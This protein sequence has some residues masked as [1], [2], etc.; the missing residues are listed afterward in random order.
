AVRVGGVP[1]GC[2]PPPPDQAGPAPPRHPQ[3]GGNPGGRPPRPPAPHP[4]TGP[5]LRAQAPARAAARPERPAGPGDVT[6]AVWSLE[7]GVERG[8][9]TPSVAQDAPLIEP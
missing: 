4:R 9:R 8:G 3:A 6:R 1:V 5:D 7:F 2:H